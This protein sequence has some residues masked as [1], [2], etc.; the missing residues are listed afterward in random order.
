SQPLS[1][2]VIGANGFLGLAICRA[3]LRA[4]APATLDYP[5]ANPTLCP[6]RVYGLVRRSSAAHELSVNE[7]VPIVGDIADTERT[8][9]D[10][11][12]RSPRWDVIVTCT[13]PTK[14]DPVAEAEHWNA[15]L[16]LVVGLAEASNQGAA[17]ADSSPEARRP[18]VLWSSGCKDYGTTRLD[19]DPE[20]RPHSEASPLDAPTPIRGRTDAALKAL[21][22]AENSRGRGSSGFDVAILRATPVYGYSGSYF[23]AAFEYASRAKDV[24]KVAAEPN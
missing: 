18:Y 2:L 13:E 14:T 10:I 17:A 4:A 7:V 21:E 20:L 3:F 19:G 12:S 23:G 15:L 24:A 11:L 8:L 22:L 5:G 1:V 9:R 16:H 6:F